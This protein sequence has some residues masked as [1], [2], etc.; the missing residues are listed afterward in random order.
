MLHVY[1]HIQMHTLI[2]VQFQRSLPAAAIILYW[3]AKA[4]EAS[5]IIADQ[6]PLK[7]SQIPLIIFILIICFIF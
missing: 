5:L 7:K 4:K 2:S 6:N 1:S 3:T